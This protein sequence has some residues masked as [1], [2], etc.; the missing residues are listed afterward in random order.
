MKQL[1]ISNLWELDWKQ[2][3]F[4]AIERRETSWGNINKALVEYRN[5]GDCLVGVLVEEL[6]KR[7]Y[8]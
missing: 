7:G 5:A 4:K 1:T 3:L 8:K 2:I 6:Q